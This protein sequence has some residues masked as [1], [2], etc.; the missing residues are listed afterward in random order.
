MLKATGISKHHPRERGSNRNVL[1][2]LPEVFP[3]V[4]GLHLRTTILC[5]KILVKNFWACDGVLRRFISGG[6]CLFLVKA[7][8]KAEILLFPEGVTILSF[9]WHV[10]V[11]ATSRALCHEHYFILG[12][13]RLPTALC[14]L[15]VLN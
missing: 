2:R 10:K 9:C 11:H 8:P 4:E 3:S 1:G 13:C 15:S 6:G 7:L 12:S 14:D 5:M